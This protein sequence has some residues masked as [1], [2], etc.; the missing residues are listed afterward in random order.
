MTI[1]VFLTIFFGLFSVLIVRYLTNYSEIYN[2][3]LEEIVY[4][5]EDQDEKSKCKLCSKVESL[6]RES[7]IIYDL[8]FPLIFMIL[9]FFIITFIT[10]YNI[11][12]LLDEKEKTIYFSSLV[13]SIMLFISIPIF[14][15]YSG[16]WINKTGKINLDYKIF[17]IWYKN[18]CY[19]KKRGYNLKFHPKN[20]YN[21]LEEN[22]KN[23][24]I[25]ESDEVIKL[26]KDYFFENQKDFPPKRILNP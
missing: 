3:W 10:I 17:T 4:N 7:C 14:L 24:K 23:N 8:F 2:L 15:K 12:P 9:I 13:L 5:Y 22:I 16:S 1:F 26:L 19:A 6:S 18:K 25:D 11:Y 20:L 21:I